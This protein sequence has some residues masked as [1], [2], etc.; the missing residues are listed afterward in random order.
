MKTFIFHKCGKFDEQIY[1]LKL[2]LKMIYLGEA[3]NGKATK[4]AR[5]HVRKFQVSIQH[6]SGET[7][8]ILVQIIA[9]PLPNS[10]IFDRFVRSKWYVFINFWY[11]PLYKMLSFTPLCDAAYHIFPMGGIRSSDQK[12]S[13][14]YVVVCY[15]DIC[16]K[17]FSC[18]LLDLL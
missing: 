10:M 6:S 8:G 12:V 9:L 14:C 11:K 4:T 16:A 7:S 15:S 5:S 3:F 17:F 13:V 1:L 18:V 2:K